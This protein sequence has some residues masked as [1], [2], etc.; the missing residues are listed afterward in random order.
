MEHEGFYYKI[1]KTRGGK[2][3]IFKTCKGYTVIQLE[4]GTIIANKDHTH[5]AYSPTFNMQQL[6][7]RFRTSL[8]ERSKTTA[9]NIIY[10]DESLR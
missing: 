10:D 7:K 8:I 3:N 6:T 9:L 1:N 2:R 5:L 4:N